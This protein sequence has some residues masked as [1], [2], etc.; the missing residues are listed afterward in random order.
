LAIEIPGNWTEIQK[1]NLELATRWRNLTDTVFKCYLGPKG[2]G[3]A[4]TD[5]G[6]NSGKYYLMA[7]RIEAIAGI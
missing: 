6:V 4:V 2:R 5:V 3:Y 7:R 1:K